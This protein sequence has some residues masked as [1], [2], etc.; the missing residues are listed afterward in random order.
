MRLVMTSG[1]RGSRLSASCSAS[2]A[3]SLSSVSSV[4]SLMFSAVS[5]CGSDAAS[6]SSPRAATATAAATSASGSLL[7]SADAGSSVGS[8][9]SVGCD[10]G[11][12]SAC[13]FGVD[14]SV[15]ENSGFGFSTVT[16]YSWVPDGRA[17]V[18][19]E[20]SWPRICRGSSARRL[21]R[22]RMV[23]RRAIALEVFVRVCALV[24]YRTGCG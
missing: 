5:D 14:C 12:S 16:G 8:E 2:L 9:V 11:C 20:P 23:R 17:C 6:E 10:S 7:L 4:F 24:D 21:W 19:I 13:S 18:P 15:S 22:C 1:M 3:V